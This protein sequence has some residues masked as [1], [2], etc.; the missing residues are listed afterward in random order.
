MSTENKATTPQ[1][2]ELDDRKPGDRLESDGAGQRD[3]ATDRD[4]L[5]K[6]KD[7]QMTDGML[8]AE[9][10]KEEKQRDLNKKTLDQQ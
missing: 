6:E 4:L 7:M 8:D 10:I 5:P 1:A 3:L 2:P 9:Q